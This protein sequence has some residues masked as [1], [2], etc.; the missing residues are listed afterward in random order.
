M[1]SRLSQMW[2][3]VVMT[4][5][6][7]FE[8]LFGNL[9]RDAKA[10]GGVLAVGDGELNAVLFLQFGQAFVDNVAPRAAE[11]VSNEEYAQAAC[12]P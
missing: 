6:P 9:R 7:E 1:I 8:Q 11:N 4:S 10:S 5:M 12:G 3:P 2:L